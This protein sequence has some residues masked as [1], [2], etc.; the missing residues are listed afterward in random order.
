M[1]T[2]DELILHH[3]DFSNFSEKV[4]L[5]LGLKGLAW[6]SVEVPSTA[7]KPD[8]TPLTGGHR[9]VPALQIG[10]DI[11]ADTA[12]IVDELER[13]YPAPSLYGGVSPALVAA[14]ATWAERDLLWPLARYIT[15]LHADR[16]PES[17]HHDRA[18]LH[19]KPLPTVA[20]VRASAARNLVQAQPQL[21]RVHDLVFD[22]ILAADPP[23]L[24]DIVVYHPIWLLETIGGPS[25]LIDSVPPTR[26]WMGRV[27][28]LGQGAPSEMAAS[29]ALDV[30]NAATPSQVGGDS[31]LPEGLAV[32]DRVQVGPLEQHSPAEGD[33]WFMDDRRIVLRAGDERVGEVNVH[34]PR[35][36]YLVRSAQ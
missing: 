12:I 14:L 2:S 9:R 30:A 13:R 8:F 34:F 17:F 36:G 10:A 35:A 31:L 7:P 1:T 33:L 6:H 5:M 29:E 15:G 4:R 25:P 16:F 20:Q 19:G 3:Y 21:M 27:A 28:A 24:A 11:Y 32:G 22:G 26:A 18:G 23:G